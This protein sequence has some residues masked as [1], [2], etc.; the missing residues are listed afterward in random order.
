MYHV[1]Y[2]STVSNMYF[3]AILLTFLFL[4]NRTQSKAGPANQMIDPC[5]RKRSLVGQLNVQAATTEEEKCYSL[6]S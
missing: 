4:F 6:N 2:S 1:M 3:Y 5:F